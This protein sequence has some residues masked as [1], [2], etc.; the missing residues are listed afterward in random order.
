MRDGFLDNEGPRW[1][2]LAW[3]ESPDQL[4]DDAQRQLFQDQADLHSALS[5]SDRAM[6][7]S[8]TS[9]QNESD[10]LISTSAPV[11][12]SP[13]QEWRN[14][15]QDMRRTEPLAAWAT[16]THDGPANPNV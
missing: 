13:S 9:P 6:D 8:G 11:A 14:C 5:G 4:I 16:G 15:L 3:R 2:P 1:V 10:Q 7:G 12:G